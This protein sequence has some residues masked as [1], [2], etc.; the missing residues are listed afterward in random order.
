MDT[1]KAERSV[2]NVQSSARDVL[3]V[4][5]ALIVIVDTMVLIVKMHVR[6][7]VKIKNAT[8]TLGIVMKDVLKDITKTET[9]V[10]TALTHVRLV[11]TK[12]HVE[13]VRLGTGDR[14][15]R[16]TAQLRATNV[17]KMGNAYKI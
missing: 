10:T 6:Q 4:F 11:S 1:T 12:T 9:N 13:T 7:V 17:Q 5:T 8:K 2:Q 14:N 3:T 15:V 16:M